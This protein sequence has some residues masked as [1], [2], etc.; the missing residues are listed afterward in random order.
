MPRGNGNGPI[1]MGLITG[2]GRGVCASPTAIERLFA[3]RGF[4]R[5]RSERRGCRN[6]LYANTL[7]WHLTY[8]VQQSISPEEQSELLKKQAE[9]LSGELEAIRSRLSELEQNKAK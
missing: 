9:H 2:R 8:S 4:G 3:N 6:Q 7:G 1:G 5:C